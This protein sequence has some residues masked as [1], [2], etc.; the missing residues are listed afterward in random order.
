MQSWKSIARLLNEAP[1]AQYIMATAM[2]AATPVASSNTTDAETKRMTEAANEGK[3]G[4]DDREDEEEEGEIVTEQGESGRPITV[5]EDPIKFNV[6][7]PLM[8]KW[9]MWY[10]QPPTQAPGADWRDLLK[11]VITFDSVEEFWGT[12]NNMAKPSDLASKSD[13]H[14]FRA[15]VRPEWEDE[16]NSNGGRWSYQIK[17][18]PGAGAAIL[19]EMWMEL[20]LAAI[21]ETVDEE[22]LNEVMGVVCNVRAK[23]SRLSI[24]TRTCDNREVLL[25]IG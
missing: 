4:G 3:V 22:G 5:L 12:Y 18:K 2:E 11:E 8:G 15:G 9:T 20:I 17:V 13:L 21:G 23:F 24:W 25:R 1:L 10:T 16:Q 19:D 14:V 7:H 6:K